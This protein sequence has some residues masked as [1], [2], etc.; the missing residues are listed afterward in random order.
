MIFPS[1]LLTWFYFNTLIVACTCGG[2][3]MEMAYF[4]IAILVPSLKDLNT[5]STSYYLLL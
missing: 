4:Y 3:V 5:S 1:N 2:Y